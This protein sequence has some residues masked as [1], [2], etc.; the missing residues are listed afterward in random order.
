MMTMTTPLGWTDMALRL[1]LTVLAGILFGYNRS[2]HG[3][4]AGKTHD[5]VG[6]PGCLDRNAS[7]EP[8]ASNVGPTG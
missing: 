7:S 5:I 1:A 6:L 2:E 4:A 3:E 8:V